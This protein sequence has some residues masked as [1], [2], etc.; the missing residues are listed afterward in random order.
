MVVL[1]NCNSEMQFASVVHMGTIRNSRLS[2]TIGGKEMVGIF[3]D[4]GIFWRGVPFDLAN[5]L[6]QA[7]W[8]CATIKSAGKTKK[9]ITPFAIEYSAKGILTQSIFGWFCPM[10]KR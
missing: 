9:G 4:P 1:G 8:D 5:Y 3:M 10:P 6:T 2:S 7:P